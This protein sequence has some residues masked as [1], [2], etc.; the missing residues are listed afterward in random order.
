MKK[1]LIIDGNSILNRA[2]Y[3]IRPLY[4]KDGKPTGAIYGLLNIV[5]RH[6]DAIRPDYAAVAFDLKAPNFRKQRF[7]YYKEGRHET[8]PELLA[9][10]DDAK[11]CL[12][13]LGF[14]TLEKEGY[15]ADD[16]LGTLSEMGKADGDTH[17]YVLSGDRDLLQLIDDSTTVL[18]ASTGETLSFDRDA[19][20]AK[21]GI[22]PSEFVDLKALMGDSSDH[23]Y[24]VPGIGEKT[25]LK[26]IAEFHSLENL[27]ASLDSPSI[28]KG[29]R[30]KLEEG[31]QSALDS[32]FLAE[33]FRSVPLDVSIDDLSYGGV[34]PAMYDKCVSLEFSGLIK[35]LSLVPTAVSCEESKAE[36]VSTLPETNADAKVLLSAFPEGA[37]FA[38][39]ADEGGFAFCN[40]ENVF[41][42]AGGA[43]PLSSLFDGSRTVITFDGKALLHRLW[44]EGVDAEFTPRDLLLYA[45]VLHSGDGSHS[46]DAL[47]LR[48]L[49]ETVAEESSPVCVFLPL[50]KAMRAEIQKIGCETLLEEI[51]LPLSPVLARMEREGFRIDTA[52]LA[53]FGERLASEM[54]LLVESITAHAGM[55]FNLN[56]P[57]QLGEVL[58]THLG[59]PTKGLKKN[60]NGY[61]TD[62]DT[63]S[64]LR[65]AHPIVDELLEYRKVSKLYSTYAQGLLKVADE[66]GDIHT[67]FKQALTATGRL[68]SAEPNLQNIPIR[69]P[70]GRE[71]RRVF[72]PK[73]KNR[74]L[75]DADY[76]QIE[77]RLLAAFSKDE[78]M[79]DSF[80]SGADIHR[81]TAAAVFHLPEELV[82]DDLRA[83]A[84]AVN[85]GI[86]YGI[87]AYSLSGDIGV[88]VAEA[89]RYMDNYFAE[90]PRIK[91]YLDGVIARAEEDGFTTTLFGRRR[92]IPELSSRIFAQRAFG[93]RVAMNSPIQGSAAD[94]IKLAMVRADRR[95]RT[96]GLDARLVMQ[97]H[98]ELIVEAAAE[99]AEEVR[100]ILKEEMEGAVSLA[101]P[102]TVS[103]AIG[104]NWLEAE[105]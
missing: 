87:S 96:A 39:L 73:A 8:P 95:L 13:L 91:D 84:K 61:S 15:E 10:F 31:R 74:V 6:L 93:K 44:R 12:R 88:S 99:C 35:K 40:G 65:Y 36:T 41:H 89:K 68:S 16:I 22:E 7:P 82:P 18:L 3:G 55:E 63:L 27:Y 9:Q 69:T 103:T 78:S 46:P 72:I 51:E 2:F 29:A 49:G 56:S 28:A 24:G 57:K 25:A 14:H 66:D 59:L 45:Y 79:C 43:L 83:R 100:T 38:I 81:R 97:V 1:A 60:K 86:I 104:E 77:L 21:Y 50:E 90:F 19:F 62:V 47:I 30:A 80:L 54:T 37:T 67:D 92:Y 70:L 58:F 17:T 26:L 94:I 53:A 33:I 71:L 20:F 11:E 4:T 48:Y 64:A 101:V 42:Y 76:S 52:A 75:V 5:L 32:R 23:I 102:L 34:C 105:H 98:D 85:F